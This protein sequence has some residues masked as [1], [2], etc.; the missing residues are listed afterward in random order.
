MKNKTQKLENIDKP[1]NLLVKNN[2]KKNGQEK[3][4]DIR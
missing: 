3:N 2:N 1:K 4:T